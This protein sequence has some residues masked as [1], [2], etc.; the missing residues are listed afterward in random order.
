MKE[1]N[2]K[3]NK[4]CF[5]AIK[6]FFAVG[7]MCFVI[8]FGCLGL[9]GCSDGK[10]GSNG[11]DGSQWFSGT[12]IPS[13]SMGVD[14]DFYLDTD[15]Y[16]LYQKTSGVWA[17]RMT[18]FGR[19]GNNGANGKDGT[20][21]NDGLTPSISISSDGYWVINN[22][23]TETK[24]S[25]EDGKDGSTPT[26]SIGDDGY[27]VIN[28]T[29]TNTKAE[30]IN[31]TNG[32]DGATWNVG[33][34][35]P[36][37]PKTG[38]LFL[39][40]ENWNIYLYNGSAWEYKGNIKGAK[41]DS[42][43]VESNVVDLVMFMGQS[44]M[45]G[46]GDSS[47]EP[48][49]EHGHG[50]EFRAVSDPTKLYDI[51]GPFGVNE[52]RGVVSESSKTGSMVP[53]LMNS[54]Y[55]HTGVPIVGVSSSKGGTSI[56]FWQPNGSALN[57]SITRYNDAKTYLENNGYVIRHKYMVWCQGET[58]GDN[59]MD[60]DTYKTKL[61]NTINEM[62]A[63]GIEKTMIIRIGN[64]RDDATLYDNIIAA[65]SYLCATDDDVVM[66]SG[67]LAGM[68]D[69]GMMKDLF[70]YTQE[71]YNIAGADAGKNMAFYVNNEIEPYFYDEEYQ[72]YYPFGNYTG[73]KAL[74]SP[75]VIINGET[76][77][78]DFSKVG[79]LSENMLTVSNPS[80]SEKL[81][82]N[83][84][85]S[86]TESWTIEFVVGNIAETDAAVIVNNGSN[87]AGFICLPMTSSSFSGSAQ[88]RLRNT[89]NDFQIDMAIPSDYD[90]TAKHHFAISYNSETSEF[91]AYIDKVEAGITYTKGSQGSFAGMSLTNLLGGYPV[92]E[93]QNFKG[94]F[95]ALVFTNSV[96]TTSQMCNY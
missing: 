18:N 16:I 32:K 28:G 19:P 44:N 75:K 61:E 67:K 55:E 95:Y 27:W 22:V 77:T 74:Y 10:D 58:D 93:T 94:D 62:K 72:N 49:V 42:S 3:C 59:K 45:A 79:T 60:F 66:I 38:D 83:I 54:Y 69:K 48:T 89:E 7:L 11:K 70:H 47:K 5:S 80:T 9:V 86:S 88:F 31:G 14:G 21:G 4:I 40:N 41:G 35:Y 39:N 68:A 65:Q 34:E 6:K 85:L 81:G 13:N 71:A 29:K 2:K 76:K 25:G 87:G 20:N 17:V 56:D 23:K 36:T 24:A 82:V 12:E 33:V 57:E 73:S 53:A 30:A 26:I 15:D 78:L 91:K 90:P 8:A 92:S 64:Q 50:Y 37:N 63:Q 51:S 46:R 1:K 84:N 43:V 96:L 52:N